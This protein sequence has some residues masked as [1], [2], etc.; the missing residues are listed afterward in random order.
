MECRGRPEGARPQ[1]KVVFTAARSASKGSPCVPNHPQPGPRQRTPAGVSGQLLPRHSAERT[2]ELCSFS[3]VIH[4]AH[5]RRT[6][7]ANRTAK[8]CPQPARHQDRPANGQPAHP[9][10]ARSVPGTHPPRTPR[11]RSAKKLLPGPLQFVLCRL[12][13]SSGLSRK[14]PLVTRRVGGDRNPKA[15]QTGTEKKAHAPTQDHPLC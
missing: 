14:F 9:S 3:T 4:R 2:G 12:A 8:R 10:E 1:S 6:A 7:S 15:G 11:P 5:S 13:S